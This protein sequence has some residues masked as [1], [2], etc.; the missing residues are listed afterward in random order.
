MGTAEQGLEVCVGPGGG[1]WGE[2][3]PLASGSN[4]SVSV[5]C[6]VHAWLIKDV[7]HMCR[8]VTS[9]VTW[10]GPPLRR[11]LHFS[12]S[13][14]GVGVGGVDRRQACPLPRA[15]HVADLNQTWNV[16]LSAVGA[17]WGRVEP[18]RKLG[19]TAP[20]HIL[21]PTWCICRMIPTRTS[22]SSRHFSWWW[23]LTLGPRPAAMPTASPRSQNASM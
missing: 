12:L 21:Y 6:H 15:H 5:I 7:V 2:G 22:L 9:P 13:W 18:S 8:Q 4:G 10:P 17:Q 3:E 16:L 14:S 20:T 19:L 1:Q 23:P 11:T